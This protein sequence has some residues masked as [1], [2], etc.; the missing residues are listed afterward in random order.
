MTDNTLAHAMADAARAMNA[1]RSLEE[2]LDGIV[3]AAALAV[4]GMDHVGISVAH[5]KGKIE[6]KAA[7]SQL[8]W[9][10][11]QMQYEID[12][13]PCVYTI[14]EHPV[15]VVENLRHEQRWPRYVPR[16]AQAGIRAQLG[17]R[18]FTEEQTLGGLN[19]YSTTG[20]TVPPEAVEAVSLFA[21]HAALAL[22]KARLEADLHSAL[23][24]R[25]LIGQA[26]G[27]VMERYGV[28]EERA[29]AFLTRASSTSNIK[30]RD[31]AR[32]LVGTVEEKNR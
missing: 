6:T 1:P 4:P 14:E 10:L 24:T 11:D 16:A 13:G 18:L 32:E 26:I 15:V 30:L 17:V 9:E 22:G 8:V 28:D 31:I 3:R 19:L 12:E 20:D 25:K 27:I 7:T 2:T 23:D 5:R 21:A 29:F